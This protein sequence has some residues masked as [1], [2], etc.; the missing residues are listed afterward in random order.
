VAFAAATLSMMR[1]LRRERPPDA[2]ER[3]Q[4]RRDDTWRGI[5]SHRSTLLDFLSLCASPSPYYLRDYLCDVVCIF[6]SRV[7]VELAP[8]TG[9]DYALLESYI[10]TGSEASSF[11]DGTRP[12]LVGTGFQGDEFT[13]GRPE[14]NSNYLFSTLRFLTGTGRALCVVHTRSRRAISIPKNAG[15]Y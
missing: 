15:R 11:P 8:E 9:V 12:Q 10:R 2:A 7:V 4:G 1:L 13:F 14:K 3:R 5:S 6:V